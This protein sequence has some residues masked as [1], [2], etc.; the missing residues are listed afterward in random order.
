MGDCIELARVRSIKRGNVNHRASFKAQLAQYISLRI[1]KIV[2][3][4]G[5]GRFLI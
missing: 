4:A 5:P 3:I 2:M 1:R